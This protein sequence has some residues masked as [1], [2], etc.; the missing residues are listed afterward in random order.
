MFTTVPENPHPI[1]ITSALKLI[2]MSLTT[3]RRQAE[4]WAK[5][6]AELEISQ[7]EWEAKK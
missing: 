2:D 6:V 7:G 4:Y 3:A 5:R 1:D